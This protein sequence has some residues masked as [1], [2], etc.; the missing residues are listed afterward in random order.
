MQYVHTL[1]ASTTLVL[2]KA[3]MGATTV[4][5]TVWTPPVRRAASNHVTR[6]FFFLP[7]LSALAAGKEVPP[8]HKQSL[9]PCGAKKF[10][11]IQQAYEVRS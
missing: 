8:R 7:L 6:N 11:E 10:R 1:K 4:A 2:K 9:V 5:G 3:E